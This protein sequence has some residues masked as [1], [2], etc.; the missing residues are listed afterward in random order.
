MTTAGYPL[1]RDHLKGAFAINAALSTGSERYRAASAKFFRCHARAAALSPATCKESVACS[2]SRGVKLAAGTSLPS[3]RH[4]SEE[5]IAPLA[6]FNW[7]HSPL[8]E[9]TAVVG[10][11]ATVGQVV[12][13]EGQA[14]IGCF[15][16]EMFQVSL[17]RAERVF[18]VNTKTSLFEV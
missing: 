7:H 9:M 5:A 18:A 1:P 14:R 11:V 3:K 2:T 6:R 13:N 16:F 17:I 10:P 15:R 4:Q 12:V 8:L